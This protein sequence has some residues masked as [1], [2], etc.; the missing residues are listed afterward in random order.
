MRGPAEGRG[1]RGLLAGLAVEAEI[2]RR[3]VPQKR[4][5]GRERVGGMRHGRQRLIRDFNAF[6]GVL[7]R[8]DRLGDD[9]GDRLADKAHPVGGHRIMN[10]RDRP[11]AARPHGEIGRTH[12]PGIVRDR[13]QSVGQVIGPGQYGEHAR[14]GA[15]LRRVDRDN[16]GMGMRRAQD[17]GM[18]ETR[19][20]YIVGKAAA[21][22][23]EAKILLAPHRPADAVRLILR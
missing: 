17:D 3:L 20:G 19:R 14:Q 22:G 4:R 9:E 15:R 5:A 7:G 6:G 16:A 13:P 21:P 11:E 18:G 10:G 23:D 12:Q 8:G 2:A 1:G